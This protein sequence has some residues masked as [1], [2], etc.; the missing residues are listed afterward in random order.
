MSTR[1]LRGGLTVDALTAALG[2]NLWV[3]TVLVPGIH[4]GAPALFG[5]VGLRAA[6]MAFPLVPLAVAVV[7]RSPFWLLCAF[8][9]AIL[10]AIEVDARPLVESAARVWSF[11]LMAASLVGYLIGAAYLSG[12]SPNAPAKVEGLRRL[13]PETDDGVPIGVPRRWRRRGRMY[14]ILTAFSVIFPLVLLYAIDFSTETRAYMEELYKERTPA[15]MTVMNLMLIFV[16]L[17]LFRRGFVEPLRRHR[18]A[19]RALHDQL[20]KDRRDAARVSPRPVFYVAVVAA[21]A[22]MTL[23]VVTRYH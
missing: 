1:V 23:L 5:R 6:I 14:V 7:R 12:L 13:A 11:A 21:L 20:V 4:S 10:A 2:L 16:W 22:F 15:L 17:G 3:S 18:T 19:D 9:V 8:P